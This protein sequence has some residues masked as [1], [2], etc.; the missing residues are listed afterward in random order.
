MTTNLGM[1]LVTDHD[2]P[3]KCKIWPN[4]SA[5]IRKEPGKPL[6]HV[7]ERSYRVGTTYSI[8]IQTKRNLDFKVQDD[9]E[10]AKL[11]TLLLNLNQ[12]G[13]DIP[14]VT[15]ERIDL[16]L[17]TQPLSPARRADRL[18]TFIG[19]HCETVGE[20]FYLGHEEKRFGAMAWTESVNDSE[21]IY[22]WNDIRDD[23]KWIRLPEVGPDCQYVDPLKDCII[24]PAGHARI[25]ELTASQSVDGVPSS[26]S[27][28]SRVDA[29]TA[30]TVSAQAFV[31]MWF[32]KSM[33]VVRDCAI[34]PA[35]KDA[36]YDPVR[37]DNIHFTNSIIEEIKAQIPRSR[38]VVADVTHGDD[39]AR[40]GVYLEIGI[41]LGQDIPVI[42]T[43]ERGTEPHSDI[44]SYPRLEWNRDNLPAFR[45]ALT[46]RILALKELGPGPRLP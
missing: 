21:L 2:R 6:L 42:F 33:D 12:Q 40:G 10:R 8:A 26:P 9:R 7:V 35:I 15:P 20:V 5:A 18:L 1:V 44:S 13:E 3:D 19:S 39:G 43:A 27:A 22:V 23:K 36:G 16:A 25:D 29:R 46:N 30:V 31:A 17:A 11:T 24:T 32:H 38:F 45:A 34:I 28:H 14:E 41:S 4:V 37:I